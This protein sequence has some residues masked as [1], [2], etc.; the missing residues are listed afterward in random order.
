M[1][2]YVPDFLMIY[3]D[4]GGNQHAEVIEVKPVKET[5]LQEAGKSP[6]A[7]AAAIL[8]MAKWEAARA[9]CKAHNLVF[10]VVTENDLFHQG[11]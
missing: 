5:S 7:Q 1:T 9:W 10:R 8:N 4:A 6:R 11:K 2:I 3:T